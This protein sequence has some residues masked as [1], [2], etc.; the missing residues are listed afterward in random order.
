MPLP[1]GG[2]KRKRPVS[3][4]GIQRADVARETKAAPKRAPAGKWGDIPLKK[5]PK[6]SS[7]LASQKLGIQQADV[8]KVSKSSI[9]LTYAK[10]Q[11]MDV[12][13]VSNAAALK[14]KRSAAPLKPKTRFLRA[15]A[16]A[17][18]KRAPPAKAVGVPKFKRKK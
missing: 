3:H 8:L 9:P 10:Q 4:A 13:R 7:P 6:A 16:K 15:P 1:S 11:R 2:R 18:P 17:A 12:A 5:R 14:R